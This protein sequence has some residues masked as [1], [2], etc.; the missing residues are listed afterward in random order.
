[1]ENGKA[2]RMALVEFRDVVK[3]FGGTAVLDGLSF[4]V[5]KGE[6][7][8]IVGPS[9]TGK[10]VTLR[11]IV[12]LSDSVRVLS[13]DWFVDEVANEHYCALSMYDEDSAQL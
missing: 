8:A 7:F 6:L 5:K 2:R 4:S 11:H 3:R 10:S 13:P 1:M 9:G 12:G